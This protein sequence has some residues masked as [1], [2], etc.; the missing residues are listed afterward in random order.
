MKIIS[1]GQTGVDR[2][3]LEVARE[4]GIPT[5]GSAPREF[6]TER[7]RDPSLQEF[8]LVALPSSLNKVRT[9]RNV[10]DSE[11]TVIYGELMG[12]TRLTLEFCAVNDKPC[13]VNPAAMELV[14]FLLNKG[15]S[16]LNVAG[17]RASEISPERLAECRASFRQA[18]VL[19][20]AVAGRRKR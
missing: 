6:M 8:G 4:F 16:V 10:L 2:M 20:G 9:L 7:G 15:I 19:L 14:D 1:G 18:I 3:A 11:A 13:L 5:G 17:N 12:G